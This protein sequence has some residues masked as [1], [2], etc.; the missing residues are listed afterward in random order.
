[1]GL[2][3]N[4]ERP[5]KIYVDGEFTYLVIMGQNADSDATPCIWT[6]RVPVELVDA[7]NGKIVVQRLNP[8]TNEDS[9][10]TLNNSSYAYFG[11]TI[12]IQAI[13]DSGCI[14]Y[15]AKIEVGSTRRFWMYSSP[16]EFKLNY[17]NLPQEAEK[18]VITPIFKVYEKSWHTVWSGEYT[19]QESSSTSSYRTETFT[20]G[21]M[22]S[23]VSPSETR[24]TAT[25]YKKK[26]SSS[27]SV[28]K[29]LKEAVGSQTVTDSNVEQYLNVYSTYVESKTKSVK[30]SVLTY[31]YYWVITKIEQYY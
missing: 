31:K 13:P 17:N 19:F 28:L 4:G 5:D 8:R 6:R 15:E 22:L 7:E 14:F 29:S 27:S 26:T 9:T 2:I 24:I 16:Y 12:N 1:M 21:S 11:D 25:L 30:Y 23:T 3:V 20:P 10:V 18:L